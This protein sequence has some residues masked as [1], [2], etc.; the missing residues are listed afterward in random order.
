MKIMPDNYAEAYKTAILQARQ[1][2]I[3]EGVPKKAEQLLLKSYANLIED[4]AKD[5]EQGDITEQRYT[6]LVNAI[7]K[8]FKKLGRQ[9]ELVFETSKRT[10]INRM[11][12]AHL[13]GVAAAEAATGLAV[14]VTFNDVTENV[15]S[16][17]LARRGLNSKNYKA[18]IKRDLQAAAKDIDRYLESA[19]TRGVNQRRMTQELAGILSQN[20]EEVLKLVDNGKLTRS[21]TNKALR[22]GDVSLSEYKDARSIIFETRRIVNNETLVALRTSNVI[23]QAKSPVVKGSKWKTST[24]HDGLRSSPDQCFRAGTKIK[25]INDYKNIEDVEIGDKVITHRN[26]YK[27]VTRLYRKTIPNGQLRKLRFQAGNNQLK[28]VVLTPNHPVLTDQ[29]WIR[30]GDLQTDMTLYSLRQESE[31]SENQQTD[32]NLYREVLDFLQNDKNEYAENEIEVLCGALPLLL[33]HTDNSNLHFDLE[34]IQQRI[35]GRH[36]ACYLFCRQCNLDS[37]CLSF[38]LMLLFSFQQL[39][40]TY[41]N[42][43]AHSLDFSHQSFC[44]HILLP[45]IL[46]SNKYDLSSLDAEKI[47][48]KL[49]ICF[50][51]DHTQ[52]DIFE[53]RTKR[54]QQP[55]AVPDTFPH[56]FYTQA[57]RRLDVLFGVDSHIH[58]SNI[59]APYND[60]M[61]YRY[62]DAFH[63]S[64]NICLAFHVFWLYQRIVNYNISFE[65]FCD[66]HVFLHHFFP[67][68]HHNK[69]KFSYRHSFNYNLSSGNIPKTTLISNEEIKTDGEIVYNL[70]VEDD[71]S[72]TANGL[73][74]HNCDFYEK[75]N[76]FG[77]GAGIYPSGNVPSSH[78]SCVPADTKVLPKG[79]VKSASKRWFDGNVFVINTASGNE[80]TCTP[81]HPVLT[82][83][84]FINADSVNV[85]DKVFNNVIGDEPTPLVDGNDIDEPTVIEKIAEPFLNDSKMFPIPMP[86]TTKDFNI[87]I[88]DRNITVVGTDSFLWRCI[89]SIFEKSIID[90]HF[91]F[92]NISRIREILLSC[93]CPLCLFLKGGCSA[94]SRF[95]WSIKMNSIILLRQIFPIYQPSFPLPSYLNPLLFQS[96]CNSS[97]TNIKFI[98]KRFDRSTR[99]IKRNN[100]VNRKFFSN[101]THFNIS[102]IKSFL[103]SFCAHR[104]NISNFMDAFTRFINR[105]DFIDRQI[106]SFSHN[107]SNLAHQIIDGKKGAIKEDEIIKIEVKEYH[108]YVYNIATTERYYFANGIATHNC[109]C[110]VES[111]IKSPSEFDQ[112]GYQTQ[113][114][115][116]VSA[117]EFREVAPNMTDGVF[118]NQLEQINNDLELAYQAGK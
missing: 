111:V 30:A 22:E 55:K 18:V 92:R 83:R 51:I 31:L 118:E 39:V 19:I 1:S 57:Q 42:D 29:G 104:K 76:L 58:E 2:L 4:I 20:N 64:C 77:L 5:L 68:F 69:H 52:T 34:S 35:F 70:G 88:I 94:L 65:S 96:L 61:A 9:L 101:S 107:D 46:L 17:M 28:K 25:T 33:Y 27:K 60:N 72:Y 105:N 59:L 80:L 36:L 16:L 110:H 54:N 8:R 97:P 32:D 43:K 116:T 102:F 15:L 86:T 24:R 115:P 108:D 99:F 26:R 21:A 112:P 49:D 75:V 78:V 11:I 48:R 67:V 113:E 82:D 38:F 74:V 6:E 79:K 100:F 90:S 40:Q 66:L 56:S 117:S 14:E 106:D 63:N 93:F 45:C 12:Q 13:H 109:A 7:R 44:F 62:Q 85:G 71:H 81:N 114:P 87:N 41:L 98:R 53:N 23:C 73:V 95:M 10:A 50:Q 3:A 37:L 47:H 89:K 91:I 84:G 103:N